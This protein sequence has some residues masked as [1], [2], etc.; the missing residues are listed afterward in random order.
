MQSLSGILA[1]MPTLPIR[2]WIATLGALY[3]QYGYLVVF[4][5]TLAENTAFLG[6]ILP[7]STVALLGAFY[8]RQGSLNLAWVIFYAWLG[9]VLGYHVDYLLGR[10]AFGHLIER[11]S[12]T[13]LGRRL[14]LAGR[15]RLARL[16]L[17]RYGGRAILFSHLIGHIRSFVAL[18]AGIA[19]MKYFSFLF[20]EI[21]AALLW[22]TVYCLLGYA[23]AIEFDRLQTLIEQAGWIMLGVFVL[24]FVVW[25]WWGRKNRRSKLRRRAAE[26]KN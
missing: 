20:F 22:T 8:A 19:H 25:R 26:R 2:E 13:K 5:G 21:I 6:L 17:A 23:V 9:T 4:L 7:G 24:I 3:N 1:A 16:L 14:R 11:W 10:F 12:T 15:I 18:S